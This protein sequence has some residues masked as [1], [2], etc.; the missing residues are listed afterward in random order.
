MVIHTYEGLGDFKGYYI[1][2][3]GPTKDIF[4]ITTWCSQTFG[5][6]GYRQ[7]KSRWVNQI[8]W[9]EVCFRDEADLTLFLLR[10]S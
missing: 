5:E 7:H 2:A 6:A 4:S 10:W 3:F 9:G 1:A 8:I